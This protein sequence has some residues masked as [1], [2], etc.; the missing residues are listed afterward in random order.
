M[1][2][3]YAERESEFY[4]KKSILII[5][6]KSL[7]TMSRA[8]ENINHHSYKKQLEFVVFIFVG[9]LIIA[10]FKIFDL[11]TVPTAALYLFSNLI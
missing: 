7:E 10:K 11:Y 4:L 1:T 5:S 8:L 2:M 6:S 9:F 3:N